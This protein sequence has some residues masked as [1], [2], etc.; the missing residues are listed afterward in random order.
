MIQVAK[1]LLGEEEKE[2]V[3]RVIDSG[4]IAN[5]AVVAEFENKFAQYIGK[6]YGIA[7]TSGTTALEVAFRALG[8]GSGDKVLT[9]PFSFI[10]TANAII[11]AGATPVFAD[12]DPE[13]YNI[14]PVKADEVL[15]ATPSIKAV[16]LVHLFGR[17]CNMD[18]FG[19]LSNK[20]NV[21]LL[22]DCAQCHGSTWNNQKAGS[23]GVMSCFSFYPTKNMAT[24]E[25]G[26]VLTDDPEI[27]KKCRLLINH[28][29]EVRYYH[30]M[31]G[32]N[33]RMTNIAAAIGLCQLDKLPSMNASRKKAAAYYDA[34][35]RNELVITPRPDEGHVYHQ[36]TVKVK[37]GL[38]D[39]FIKHLTEKQIGHGVFY[40]LTIPEQKC[41]AS[42]GFNA[43]YS[44]ADTLK[45]QVVSLPVHPGLSDTEICMVAEAVNTFKR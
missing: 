25:G 8:I 9:T 5:G 23:F 33:Y 45:T 21:P 19:A 38:R 43:N 32:Y 27:A 44:V 34:N 20:H 11:Y 14:D 22:E 37:K 29:M 7:T 24:G 41:Y 36:Y 18:A 31:I 40:P 4:M 35:I 28:G 16:L 17:S 15:K 2:A 3:C 26:M 30:D 1:P 42:F 10:A 6:D 13:T 12:I 39:S